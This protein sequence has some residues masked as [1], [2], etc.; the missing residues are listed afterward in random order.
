MCVLFAFVLRLF[1]ILLS[2]VSQEDFAHCKDEMDVIIVHCGFRLCTVKLRAGKRTGKFLRTGK[3][4]VKRTGKFLRAVKRTGKFLWK[5]ADRLKS[6]WKGHR[7][8]PGSYET[9]C[10]NFTFS[11]HKKLK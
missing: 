6:L 8:C 9:V 7:A 4:T 5:K 10:V 1:V 3:R 11:G 2:P